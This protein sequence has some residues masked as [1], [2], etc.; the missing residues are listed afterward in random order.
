V[1]GEIGEVPMTESVRVVVLLSIVVA[2]AA[3][4][5]ATPPHLD[6]PYGPSPAATAG[7]AP[8]TGAAAGGG[9][10]TEQ[11]SSPASVPD[12][13]AAAN[14]GD[15]GASDLHVV[16]NRLV[17]HNKTVRLL[18]VSVSGTENYCEQGIGIFQAPNDA[19]LV[20]PMKSWSINAIRVPMNEDCWLGIN[21]V[22]PE[23]GGAAYQ[24][25]LTSFVGMLRAHGMYVIVDL[26]INAPGATLAKSQQPM[27]DADHSL[28]FWRSVAKAFRGDQGVVFDLYNEP[29]VDGAR[30]TTS[31]WQCWRDGCPNTS[32]TGFSGAASTAGMQQMLDVV[33][34]AGAK[35]VVLVNGLG[36]GEFVGEMWLAHQPRDPLQNIAAGHHNYAFNAGCN[37]PGCWQATLANVAAK[38]PLIVGELGENDC[39]HGY[40]DAFFNWADPLGISYIGWTW[41]VWDCASGPSLIKDFQGTPTSFGQGFKAHLPTQNP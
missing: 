22:K 28:D 40:V 24:Q 29:N 21:G 11:A 26:H 38:V 33:R 9:A 34:A 8:G 37:T 35:N 14:T 27:A 32:W 5:A 10:R 15:A 23:Y 16:G 17:D 7:G 13:P 3:G 39:G 18:G 2:V 12:A 19:S 36:M 20:A 1:R 25:A 41:N 31:S 4:C 30:A 6:R